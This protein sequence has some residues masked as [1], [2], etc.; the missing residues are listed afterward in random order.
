MPATKP[1]KAKIQAALSAIA[2]AGL[3][4]R[5]VYFDLDGSFRCEFGS[6]LAAEGTSGDPAEQGFDWED[7]A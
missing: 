2:S 7:F 1:S 3:E 4:L 5:S 6:E